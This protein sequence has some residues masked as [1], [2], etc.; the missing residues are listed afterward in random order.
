[1]F[2][3]CDGNTMKGVL[4]WMGD[5]R[6]NLLRDLPPSDDDRS[7]LVVQ[8]KPKEVFLAK[9]LGGKTY[10]EDMLEL[11][12]L[13]VEV[14]KDCAKAGALFV[15]LWGHFLAEKR[16][17]KGRGMHLLGRVF[18][19]SFRVK[20]SEGMARVVMNM[21]QE[22]PHK[23]EAF[24]YLICYFIGGQIKRAGKA[25][26]L[27]WF[28]FLESRHAHRMEV[29]METQLHD[30]LRL[31]KLPKAFKNMFGTW[32]SDELDLEKLE[33]SLWDSSEE[34][35]IVP[36]LFSLRRSS[37]LREYLWL[38]GKATSEWK[39]DYWRGIVKFFL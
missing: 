18:K 38:W 7:D 36:S 34:E 28:W 32:L 6:N 9:L 25:L 19:R 14:E 23:Q 37:H 20:E 31:L 3:N 5:M 39:H 24:K 2:A 29:R 8:T 26:G 21:L 1:M 33:E 4:H 35:L 30:E 17:F 12:L 13:Y 10:T 22:I 27:G 11:L 16:W 15:K